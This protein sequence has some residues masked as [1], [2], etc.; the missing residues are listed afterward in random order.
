MNLPDGLTA[1]MRKPSLCFVTTL[2]PDGSPQ[3]TETWVDTDGEHVIINTVQTHQKVRNVELDPR[4]AIA[5]CDSADP[6]RYYGIRGRVV[7]VTAKGGAEHIEALAQRYTG[8]PY[9]WYGGRD[10]VRVILTVMVDKIHSM[11]R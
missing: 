7:D 8:R 11:A 5:I 1:L 2:M 4:V 9:P 6:A 3:I 10:Q